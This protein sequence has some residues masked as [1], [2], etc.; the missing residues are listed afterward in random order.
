MVAQS[1]MRTFM[2]FIYII[3]IIGISPPILALDTETSIKVMVCPA[4]EGPEILSLVDQIE[5]ILERKPEIVLIACGSGLYS[6]GDPTEFAIGV[7]DRAPFQNQLILL[8]DAGDVLGTGA[9]SENPSRDQLSIVLNQLITLM[10]RPPEDS[11]PQFPRRHS[12]AQKP[13]PTSAR[14]SLA[15]Y[16]KKAD[17][18]Y[19]LSAHFGARQLKF[20]QLIREK[21]KEVLMSDSYLPVAGLKFQYKPAAWYHMVL[22]TETSWQQYEIYEEFE[23]QIVGAFGMVGWKAEWQN[24]FRWELNSHFAV[25]SEI[26]YSFEFMMPD[27][28]DALA[29]VR[30]FLPNYVRHNIE[31][32]L[33]LDGNAFHNHFKYFALAAFRPAVSM[34]FAPNLSPW[35]HITQGYRVSFGFSVYLTSQLYVDATIDGFQTIMKPL[36][37]QH[38][39]FADTDFVVS[40]GFGVAW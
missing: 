9:L 4:G 32:G 31:I 38:I 40:L 29:Q 3:V 7:Q 5:W 30:G 36:Y 35:N 22:K 33:G 17:A 27:A 37:A 26:G 2:R 11:P 8:N 12:K 14:K 20:S 15:D 1:V 25:F 13:T 28:T 6:E 24:R 19:A 16:M 10:L 23:S 34:N 18:S 21:Y 39:L